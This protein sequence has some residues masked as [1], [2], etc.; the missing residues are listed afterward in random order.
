MIAVSN[1]CFISLNFLSKLTDTERTSLLAVSHVREFK[2]K[3]YVFRAGDDDPNVHILRR[4]RVKVI[5]TSPLGKEVL[6]WF[7]LP[8]EVFGVSENFDGQIRKVSAQTLEAS[9]IVSV[10]QAQFKQWLHKHPQHFDYIV[11]LMASR[12]REIG[13]RFLNLAT[14]N[15][16]S[17]VAKLLIGLASCYGTQRPNAVLVNLPL[18]HQDIAD[19]IG[20]SRQCVS[21]A[22]SELKRDG[23][24]S[25]E[26]HFLCIEDMERLAILAGVVGQTSK[27][28]VKQR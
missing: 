19:M 7:C 9:E 20:A 27:L 5:Q 26:R 11:G 24:L 6:L 17:Q 2:K 14:G 22:M 18:S 4:G 25:V 23:I 15:V 21:A 8:G 28:R 1:V 12:L 16:S 10:P 13:H 3:E